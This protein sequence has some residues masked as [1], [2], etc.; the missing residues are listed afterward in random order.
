MVDLS[1][2][3][4]G[5]TG[6]MVPNNNVIEFWKD[7]KQKTNFTKIMEIGFNAGHSSSIILSLFD[8]VYVHS[9]DI[10]MFEITQKN[11]DI[12]K[13]KFGERFSFTKANSLDLKP[14]VING[15]DILFIDG[16]HDLPYI[17]NDLKLAFKS[18]IE[19]VVIDD[20]QNKN[21]KATFNENK[22]RLEVVAEKVYPASTGVNVPV[23]CCRI[24]R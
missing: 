2:L 15:H 23:K 19:Y 17:Q 10:C 11:A 3:P 9:Y 7:V 8:D 5:G 14:E 4:D 24:V 1:W 16:S 20:L 12:V 21:V 18:T 6:H 13:S 22:S